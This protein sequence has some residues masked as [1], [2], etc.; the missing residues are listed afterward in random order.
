MRRRYCSTN[1]RRAKVSG[2]EESQGSQGVISSKHDRDRDPFPHH[3]ERNLGARRPENKIASLTAVRMSQGREGECDED[4]K[5]QDTR[6]Q[7]D[8]EDGAGEREEWSQGMART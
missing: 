8:G 5:G 3:F 1:E 4:T 2:R 6:R 7:E